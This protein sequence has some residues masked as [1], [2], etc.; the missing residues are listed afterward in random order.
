MLGNHSLLGSRLHRESDQ[1]DTASLRKGAHV[2]TGAATQLEHDLE[3]FSG[4]WDPPWLPG[5]ATT[6]ALSLRMAAT[7]LVH[8]TAYAQGVAGSFILPRM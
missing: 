4:S 3:N 1:S 5:T 7:G 8:I 6:E 2:R